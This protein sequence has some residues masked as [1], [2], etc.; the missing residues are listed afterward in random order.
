MRLEIRLYDPQATYKKQ[1][2]KSCPDFGKYEEINR[3]E[4]HLSK[5]HITN[6]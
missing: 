2:A 6:S 4:I 5:K 3:N 1:G